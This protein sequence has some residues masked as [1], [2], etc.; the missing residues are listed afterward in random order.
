MLA[1]ASSR[2]TRGVYSWLSLCLFLCLRRTCKPDLL[3]TKRS[4]TS[5]GTGLR[6]HELSTSDW[7]KTAEWCDTRDTLCAMTNKGRP[8]WI[9]LYL[10]QNHSALASTWI[11]WSMRELALRACSFASSAFSRAR[12][13][14][15][16]V[17]LTITSALR[18]SSR[19]ALA[20]AASA[21]FVRLRGGARVRG[22]AG[23][24]K[25]Y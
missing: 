20:A 21:R 14:A 2:F 19:V 13:A 23:R 11:S 5:V 17:M 18:I 25:A 7:V 1:L 9:C 4:S 24:G 16:R 8:G 15:C 6:T 3:T 22:S 10:N 12:A